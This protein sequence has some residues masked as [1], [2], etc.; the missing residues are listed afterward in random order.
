MRNKMF[1]CAV[2]LGALLAPTQ[3]YAW[4]E[5]V[6]GNAV[7]EETGVINAVTSE[8]DNAVPWSMREKSDFVKFFRGIDTQTDSALVVL[9][10]QMY[11]R[12]KSNAAII[13]SGGEGIDVA[14]AENNRFKAFYNHIHQLLKVSVATVWDSS[15]EETGNRY[16]IVSR[17]GDTTGYYAVYMDGKF[18]FVTSKNDVKVLDE[19]NIDIANDAFIRMRKCQVL[20]YG[21]QELFSAVGEQ[22]D[23]GICSMYHL[24]S[25]YANAVE[26]ACL[27]NSPEKVERKSRPINGAMQASLKSAALK[28]AREADEDIID[29]VITSHIWDVKT[30]GGTPVY[31]NIYGYYVVRDQSGTLCLSRAWSQDYVGDGQYGPLHEGGMGTRKPF[32]IQ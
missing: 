2:L 16:Q 15:T 14:Q 29:V 17:D 18:Q 4:F 3:S 24:C 22:C 10:S 12:Y 26:K 9:R 8:T 30:L 7:N 25:Q 20:T 13:A 31:R 11:A 27:N 5:S 6:R 28:V 32:Y 21:L 1:I 19:D 23:T